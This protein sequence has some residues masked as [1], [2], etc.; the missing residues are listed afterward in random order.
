[1]DLAAGRLGQEAMLAGDLLESLPE[2]IR[3]VKGSGTAREVADQTIRRS[4]N[5]ATG[6]LGY[7]AIG[8]LG[9]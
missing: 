7:W 4:G 2:A 8:Q 1:G 9:N 6:Q 5:W 3:L